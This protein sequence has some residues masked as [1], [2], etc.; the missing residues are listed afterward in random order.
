MS[1]VRATALT[2]SSALL[3]LSSVAPAAGKKTAPD[4]LAP[5]VHAVQ[6][7]VPAWRDSKVVIGVASTA[8]LSG[9]GAV[10]VLSVKA[11]SGD[12]A[13]GSF[14]FLKIASMKRGTMFGTAVG[15]L[16][17]NGIA[18]GPRRLDLPC[19]GSRGYELLIEARAG[20]RT[21]SA[22]ALLVTYLRSNGTRGHLRIPFAILM[23]TRDGDPR[24]P[25][26]TPTA[27]RQPF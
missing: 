6:L 11:A 7:A 3:V 17:S 10:S 14:A 5:G 16:R 22:S 4:L 2:L 12:V 18:A 26:V 13:L 19:R 21:T 27:T 24:C 20:S 9:A 25:R 8:C 1:I 23:C 15:T